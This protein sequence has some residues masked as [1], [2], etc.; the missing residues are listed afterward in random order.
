MTSQRKLR[1]MPDD[2]LLAL[3]REWSQ[4]GTSIRELAHR[5]ETLLEDHARNRR[6]EQVRDLLRAWDAM[7]GDDAKRI[8]VAAPVYDAIEALRDT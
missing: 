1:E 7:A 5:Y 4:D 3:V 2:E 8:Q 6:P